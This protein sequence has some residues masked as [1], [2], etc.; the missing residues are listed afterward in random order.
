MAY[1]KNQLALCFCIL[2][3]CQ[4]A[5]SSVSHRND[6]NTRCDDGYGPGYACYCNTECEVHNNCCS[7]YWTL[8]KAGGGVAHTQAPHTQAPYVPVNVNQYNIA[9]VLWDADINRLG[10][11][12][13]K[14]N[15]QGHT[16][17]GPSSDHA[18]YPLFSYV[19]EVKLSAPTYRALLNLWDNYATSQYTHEVTTF[20]KQSEINAF[21]NAVMKTNV[22]Q[23]TYHYL[24]DNHY[25]TGDQTAFKH[26]LQTL[27]FD[28]YS[29]YSGGPKGSSGF[30]HVFLGEFKGS[31]VSGFH[32]WLRFYKLEKSGRIDYK[33]YISKKEPFLVEFTFT[34]DGKWKPMS[35]FFI[36]SSPE[37]DMALSTICI[38]SEPN[39]ACSYT[40][41][42][43]R[44]RIQNYDNASVSGLQVA[45]AYPKT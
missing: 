3:I 28:H 19:N 26:Q 37:F 18:Y 38:L 21:L 17:L 15:Y 10:A 32:N 6:C 27:W 20:Q 8:C 45:S 2:L 39:R 13:L 11:G 33:G 5:S 29:R 23:I 30:E 44:F 25:I 43:Q 14:V 34:W 40:I 36:G 1:P 16:G 24:K 42:R 41:E 35:S 22:M 9:Q 31:S 7:D 12:D 4:S